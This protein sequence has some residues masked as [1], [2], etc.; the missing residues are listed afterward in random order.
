M[1]TKITGK[2]INIPTCTLKK[3]LLHRRKRLLFGTCVPSIMGKSL[4]SSFWSLLLLKAVTNS[5]RDI[6]AGSLPPL[7][8]ERLWFFLRVV[9]SFPI[10]QITFGVARSG[11]LTVFSYS[12]ITY[13]IYRGINRFQGNWD[14]PEIQDQAVVYNSLPNTFF[15]TTGK[16]PPR[17]PFLKFRTNLWTPYKFC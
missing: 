16:N 17:R 6:T 2:K 13:S 12:S 4:F 10:A 5:S 8:I 9:V 11:L 14:L 7:W 15:N 1:E 3:I